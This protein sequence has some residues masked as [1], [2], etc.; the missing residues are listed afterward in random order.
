MMD[1]KEMK[2]KTRDE[3]KGKSSDRYET[4]RDIN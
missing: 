4:E 2:K 1:E 3:K